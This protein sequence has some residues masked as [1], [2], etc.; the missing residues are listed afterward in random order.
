[1][2]AGSV[3][4]WME[5]IQ[6]TAQGM[7]TLA[8]NSGAK[9]DAAVTDYTLSASEIALLKGIIKQLQTGGTSGTQ[10]TDGAAAPTHPIGTQVIYNNAGTETAVSVANPLPVN[11]TL[12]PPA[13]QRV[14]AQSGDFV[15]GALTTLGAK[16]DA[17]NSAT[18][19]TAITAMQ[20]LKQI[21]YMLQNPASTPVTGTFWQAIQPVSAASLPL[22]SGA[23]KE[24]GGN[25]DTLVA[26]LGAIGDAAWGLSGNGDS[27]AILKKIALLLN[28]GLSIS[29]TVTANIDSTDATHL[30]NIDT[31]TATPNVSDRWPRQLG[32]I[33]LARVLGTAISNTN[34]V[35][36]Q[37]IEQSGYTA[38][39]SP[40]AQTSAGSETQYTFSS[41]ISR[42]ILQN[43]TTANVM[44]AF[45]ATASLGSLVLAP[46]QT[47]I[48]PKKVT[49]VHLYTAAA[50]NVNGTSAGN[51][52][53]LGAL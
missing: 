14:N 18:D 39:S 13:N 52:V 5:N 45:D 50:Q 43:N 44:Y 31:Q 51:I 4:A 30:A 27:I 41:Q 36:T 49:V 21:S 16:A 29:G 19:T 12:T 10:Y 3:S 1:M 35:P 40:A 8:T 6:D 23:A 32:Q 38:L 24:S 42:V 34:P 37:D 26:S 33:D 2:T 47:L 46:G 53:L 22:P 17:K 25:L 7:D 48:Y 11:A 9:S 15:D 20:V 28:A